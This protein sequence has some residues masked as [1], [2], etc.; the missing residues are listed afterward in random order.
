MSDDL[1]RDVAAVP[2]WRMIAGAALGYCACAV[3]VMIASVGL[4]AALGP[5]GVFEPGTY[6]SRA[7]FE[8]LNLGAGFMA[9]AIAGAIAWFMG[10]RIGVAILV[11]VML[12]GGGISGARTLGAQAA[13]T[14]PYEPRPDGTWMQVMDHAMA[15]T[16]Q[17]AVYLLGMPVAGGIGVLAGAFAASRVSRPKVPAA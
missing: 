1:T 16:Q 4:A 6:R 15:N 5:D 11:V 13:R 14:E 17:G 12:V 2:I 3:V 8:L 9:A 7:S 10:R